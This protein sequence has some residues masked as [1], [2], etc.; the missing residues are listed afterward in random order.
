MGSPPQHAVLI[1]GLCPDSQYE[2][3][4]PARTKGTMGKVPVV[5]D[6]HADHSACVGHE[7][8]CQER[9]AGIR[10]QNDCDHRQVHPEEQNVPKPQPEVG[11]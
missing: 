3:K 10:E 8:Q 7:T 1:G 2:L 9:P 5:A 4:G 6:T 11:L